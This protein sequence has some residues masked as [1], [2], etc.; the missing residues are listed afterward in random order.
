MKSA[1]AHLFSLPHLLVKVYYDSITARKSVFN[2]SVENDKSISLRFERG[3][4]SPPD[5]YQNRPSFKLALVSLRAVY[6]MLP[7]TARRR[8]SG[9]LRSV[10][11][12][13]H[14]CWG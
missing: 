4:K 11:I 12:E 7:A 1:S 2:W 13:E 10:N 6:T 14:D 3:E 9:Q 8:G 5:C